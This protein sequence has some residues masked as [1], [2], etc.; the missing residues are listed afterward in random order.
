MTMSQARVAPLPGS[1]VSFQ[2][3]DVFLPNGDELRAAFPD[4]EW[5]EGTVVGLSDSGK[6]P[7]AFAVIELVHKQNV[8]VPIEKLRKAGNA[9]C[10][11]RGG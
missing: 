7:D 9:E 3:C 10:S 6:Q 2:V 11:S 4:K 5:L 8:V 1:K